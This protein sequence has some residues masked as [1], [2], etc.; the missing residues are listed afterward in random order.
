MSSFDLQALRRGYEA[1]GLWGHPKI[2]TSLDISADEFPEKVAIVDPRGARTTF[3]ELKLSVDRVAS[4]FRA[5]GVGKGDVVAVQLPNWTEF[6]IAHLALVRIAGVTLFL[7]PTQR[8]DD[9]L[10]ILERTKPKAFVIPAKHR[11]GKH[12][13]MYEGL[14]ETLGDAFGLVVGAEAGATLPVGMTRWEDFGPHGAPTAEEEPVALGDP[15]LMVFTSGTTA[16]PKGVLHSYGTGDYHLH[17]WRQ[18]L[19]FGHE[20]VI[21]APATLGHVAGSQFGLRLATLIGAKLVLMDRW[22]PQEAVELVEREGAT[23]AFVTPT[24]L[25]DLLVAPNLSKQAF[26]SFR[27]WNLGGSRIRPDIVTEFEELAGGRILRGFGMTEHMMSSLCRPYDPLDKR[28]HTDGRPLPGCRYGIVDP[29]DSARFL[30]AGARRRLLHE[31]RGDGEDVRRRVAADRRPR[32]PR[33]GRVH[34]D[35]RPQEGRDHPRR[36]EHLAARARERPDP[37]RGDRRGDGRPLS[38]P[39]AWRAGLRGRRGRPRYVDHAG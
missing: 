9:L 24:F 16:Y 32:R 27:I 4:G 15:Q 34:D 31:R 35:R 5:A 18:L 12:V 1:Q 29:E 10:Y 25:E 19:A 26:R 7:P 21:W 36:R 6:C 11:T 39:A 17:V 3:A 30:P 2:T 37:A 13:A 8:G 22:D 23:Y 33:R 28:T 20:D 38:R 14:R